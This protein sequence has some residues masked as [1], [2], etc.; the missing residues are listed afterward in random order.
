MARI[1]LNYFRKIISLMTVRVAYERVSEEKDIIELVN[2]LRK[3]DLEEV[4]TFCNTEDV[5]KPVMEGWKKSEY[6]KTFLVND[7]VAGV[8]GLVK[9]PDNK[10]A[11]CPYLL[12]TNELYKIKKTFIKGCKQRVD[13]MLFKFPILFNYIDSRNQVHL[14]W[15]KYCGF[16]LIHE[17]Q[18]NKVKFYGFL[19]IREENYN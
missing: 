14:Q 11:A 3:P 7:K 9:S 19:K 12:C 1:V 16:N 2:N 18:I 15:I 13:E 4:K 17:K 6:A 10:R 8:Y 5:L